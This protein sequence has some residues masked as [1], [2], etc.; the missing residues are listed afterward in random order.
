LIRQTFER[1]VA[2]AKTV[3]SAQSYPESPQTSGAVKPR[4]VL[5]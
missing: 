4:L 3:R 5:V 2:G 1:Y